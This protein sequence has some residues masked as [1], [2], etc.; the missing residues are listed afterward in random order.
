MK[1]P[2]QTILVAVSGSEQS[3]KA[4]KYGIALAKS[5]RAR[6]LAAYVVDTDTL[7]ELL[8]SR[9]FVEEES[10]DY[11]RNLERNGQNYLGYVAEL[12]QKKGVAVEKLLRRGA[13]STEII[14][15]AR[16][17]K[18]DL[19]LLG[20]FEGQTN[21]RDLLGRQHREIIRNQAVEIVDLRTE[22][23]SRAFSHQTLC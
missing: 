8:L 20:A 6:L 5:Y 19:I 10:A 11:Q 22:R 14:E 17:Y 21:L 12:G 3:I 23:S 13:V 2:L 16:E 9:I 1:T 18:A 15:A 7:K 4:A